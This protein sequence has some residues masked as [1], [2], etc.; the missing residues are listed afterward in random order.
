MISTGDT[1]FVLTQ[2]SSRTAVAPGSRRR[3]LG[4]PSSRINTSSSP[5]TPPLAF[6]TAY[7]HGP[8]G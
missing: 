4:L 2:H 1:A 7:A 8:K 3:P 6:A 5:S